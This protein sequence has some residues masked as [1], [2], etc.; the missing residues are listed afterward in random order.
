MPIAP[1]P[2]SK[3]PAPINASE[4]AGGTGPRNRWAVEIHRGDRL[5]ENRPSALIRGEGRAALAR[6]PGF[7]GES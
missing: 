1:Q 6:S 3:K 5:D 2:S 4:G 7:P